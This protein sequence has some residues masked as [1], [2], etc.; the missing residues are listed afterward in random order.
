MCAWYWRASS[1]CA[2]GSYK[3]E[4]G[5]A[6]ASQRLLVIALLYYVSKETY[7]SV[8]RDLLQCQKRPA[9]VSK[10]TYYSVKR[11]LLQCQKKPTSVKRD[12]LQCL[13]LGLRVKFVPLCR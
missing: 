9:T 7:Y 3:D 2:A 5:A 13:G 1:A 12:L 11:D 6:E 4:V 10:E 8:K